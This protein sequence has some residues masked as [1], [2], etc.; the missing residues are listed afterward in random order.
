[1]IK[2]GKLI[3]IAGG[4]RISPEL[5]RP[6]RNLHQGNKVY[7]ESFLYYKTVLPDKGRVL[8]YFGGPLKELIIKV[9]SGFE[10]NHCYEDLTST[11]SIKYLTEKESVVS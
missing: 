7:T 2:I 6:D 5:F 8:F 11:W 4:M 10:F 1:M 9:N 3:N